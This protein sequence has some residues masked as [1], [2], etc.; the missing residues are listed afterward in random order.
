MRFTTPILLLLLILLPIIFVLGKPVRGPARRREISAL[1]LRVIIVLCVILALAGLEIARASDQLAVVFLLDD[2][3]SMSSEAKGLAFDYARQAIHDMGPDDQ[4]AV[5]VFG[6]D[7]LVE[8]AMSP[9]RELGALTSIPDTGQTNL[10]DAIRL[11]L[12]L[13]P[14]G[15]ARRMIILSDGAQTIGDAEEAA[16][17]AAASGVEIV[18]LPFVMQPGAEALIAAVETPARLRTGERFD[19]RVSIDATQA[20]STRLRVLANGQAVHE[21]SYRLNKGHQTISIPLTATDPGFTRFTVQI[22]PQQDRLYQNNE[23]AATAQVLGEPQILVVSLPAGTALP[24]N[25][26]RPD[27]AAQLIRAL[28]AANFNIETARPAQLPSDAATLSN[29]ASVVLV[30]VPARE[31]STRQMETLRSYVRDLGGGLVAIGGPTSYGVGGYYKTPIEDALPVEMQIKDQQRRPQLAMVFIIDH[32]GSMGETSGGVTK[33]DLAKEAAARSVELLMPNDRV[34]VIAFD[35]V[36]GWV[37]PLGELSDPAEVTNRIGTIRVGGGTDIYA[38][39]LAMSKVLPGDSAQVKHVILLTDGGADPTGIPELVK[40]LHD[41]DNITLTTVGVGRDAAPFLPH[42]AELGGGRYHFAADPGSIPS[43]FTEETTL[44]SRSYIEEH[45]FFPKQ[46][47]SSPLLNGITEAPPL[48]GY[49]ATSPKAAA[50]MILVSDQSDPVLA[51][52]QYGLG[53]AVAFT[54]DATGRWAREW[55]DWEKF[56]QFWGQVVRYTIGDPNASALSV[57]VNQQ[58]AAARVVVDARTANGDY[59]NGCTLNGNIVAPDGST[60]PIALQQTAPGRYEGSFQP[61]DQGAYVI[62]VS[63]QSAN[64]EVVNERAGWVLSYSPEYRNLESDPD[65]LYQLALAAHGQVATGDPADAVVHTPA[66]RS[67]PLATRPVWPWLLLIAALLLPFDVGVRRLAI[68]RRD[69]QKAWQAIRLKR[70]AQRAARAAVPARSEHMTTLFEAKQRTRVERVERAEPIEPTTHPS[71]ERA[72]LT[73]PST[74]QPKRVAPDSI[75]TT[76][77]LLEKKRA[78]RK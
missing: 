17:F 73:P 11:G 75:A 16:R 76:A 42:L 70:Q 27:E 7:A 18:T 3:D 48:Y 66:G 51:A 53:K 21:A 41:E 35:D 37:V 32:S 15:A 67:A 5:V 6:G 61:R 50:Q 8:R 64:G 46:A 22:D 39:V 33:L 1:G 25:E 63:G 77:N 30:D 65:A 52:S 31:L 23:L 29:Y 43:I 44:A 20:M 40:K 56:P 9:S 13:Y 19:L 36:A 14:P 45:Q 4:A 59:L 28:Q 78:R 71:A 34:G 68:D 62:G 58:G 49:V 26:T 55:I 54:S 69:V 2:S 24:N 47:A 72:E 12:A 38:G 10:A 74:S 57:S 60:Q